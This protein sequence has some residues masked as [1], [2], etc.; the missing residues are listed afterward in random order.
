MSKEQ[1]NKT[2]KVG[3]IVFKS[4]INMELINYKIK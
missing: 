2:V 1:T 3:K 4:T